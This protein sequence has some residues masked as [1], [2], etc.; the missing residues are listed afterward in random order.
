MNVLMI[1]VMNAILMQYHPFLTAV[2][3]DCFDDSGDE[4]Y[5][6]AI[7]SVPDSGDE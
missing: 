2:M 3:N 6:D 7:S 5:F 4:C 1:A